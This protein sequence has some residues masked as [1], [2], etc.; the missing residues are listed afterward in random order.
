MAV[1]AGPRTWS[2]VGNAAAGS[3]ALSCP[4]YPS[5]I[6][7][8]NNDAAN[9]FNLNWVDSA[10]ATVTDNSTNMR[11]SFGK[12]YSIN[13]DNPQVVGPFVINIIAIAGTPA[14]VINAFG[15]R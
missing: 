11:C 3:V 12:V 4:F 9:A 2:K 8:E 5:T 6:T 15:A 1:I 14:Y 13:F 10:G 7:V